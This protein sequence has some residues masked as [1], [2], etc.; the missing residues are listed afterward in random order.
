M[1]T[2]AVPAFGLLDAIPP[3]LIAGLFIALA[4]LLREP[5]RQKFNAIFVAGAGAAYLNG[6]LGPLEFAFTA[7]AT[8]VAYRGL[9]SYRFIGFA[10]ILHTLW[11]VAHHLYGRP[12]VYFQPTSS[13]GCAITDTLIA[14][15]F[16]ANAPSV[17]EVLRTRRRRLAS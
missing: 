11:D 6:G 14:L 16:F 15:W 7:V 4:S 17:Y 5:T 3:V 12:I 13:A 8:Y 9:D 10:W 2:H 1:E